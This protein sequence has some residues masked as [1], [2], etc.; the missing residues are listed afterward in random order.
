M[1][2]GSPALD[3]VLTVIPN[4]RFD[5]H[6]SMTKGWFIAAQSGKVVERDILK[7]LRSSNDIGLSGACLRKEASTPEFNT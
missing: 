2:T 6:L 5:N 7:G 4:K 1:F 3:L